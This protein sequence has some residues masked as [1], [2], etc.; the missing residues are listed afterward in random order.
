MLLNSVCLVTVSVANMPCALVHIELVS[1][2]LRS[3][4]KTQ[5]ERAHGKR[6]REEFLLSVNQLDGLKKATLPCRSIV[7]LIVSFDLD[8]GSA[9]ASRGVGASKP[10]RTVHT[11]FLYLYIKWSSKR[12]NIK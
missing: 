6:R 10:C 5:D 2:L 1:Q 3:E 4:G 9:H 12:I 11:T 7:T 8:F